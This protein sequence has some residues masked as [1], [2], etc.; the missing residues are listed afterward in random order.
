MK[1][2]I[3]YEL[4]DNAF[5]YFDVSWSITNDPKTVK[6]SLF[7]RAVL[8][9]PMQRPS[10]ARKLPDH[11]KCTSGQPYCKRRVDR[12]ERARTELHYTQVVLTAEEKTAIEFQA[13][14]APAFGNPADLEAALDK[15]RQGLADDRQHKD[16]RDQLDHQLTT[17]REARKSTG[18][19]GMHA[20][21]AVYISQSE[22]AG[23]GRSSMPLTI[24]V[25]P[26]LRMAPKTRGTRSFSGISHSRARRTTRER[27]PKQTKRF[28]TC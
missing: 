21:R 28:R 14:P 18:P 5:D 16:E 24:Y 2:F 17:L 25:R 11:R 26:T 27:A 12:C 15:R 4:K 19:G 20:V 6:D 1:F 10:L 3:G 8:P 23:Q 7:L 13:T 9:G 22:N